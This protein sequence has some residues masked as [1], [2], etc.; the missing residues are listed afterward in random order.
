MTGLR[1]EGRLHGV[2]AMMLLFAWSSCRDAGV[3]GD[4]SRFTFD[5]EF[6]YEVPDVP[7]DSLINVRVRTSQTIDRKAQEVWSVISNF[8][9][10]S[11]YLGPAIQS[12]EGQ[13]SGPD[14][15]RTLVLA[16][17]KMSV[18]EKVI[19]QVDPRMIMSYEM[20]S[21]DL[22]LQDYRETLRVRITP[23]GGAEVSAATDFV[24]R[25]QQARAMY[26]LARQRH[27]SLYLSL[28]EG[29]Q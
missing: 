29:A 27:A 4:P 24:T 26:D 12:S 22:P 15:E 13:G 28:I 10:A 2:L 18:R 19:Q 17:G 25:A 6:N 23:E 16:G 11:E 20:I 14:A 1:F 21:G 3:A 7:P 5:Y 8:G 9:A